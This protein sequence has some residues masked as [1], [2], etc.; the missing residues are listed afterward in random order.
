MNRKE[1]EFDR[2]DEEMVSLRRWPTGSKSRGTECV[3]AGVCL[4]MSA[5]ACL[6]GGLNGSSFASTRRPTHPRSLHVTIPAMRTQQQQ[7]LLLRHAA[8]MGMLAR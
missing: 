7:H 3:H 5:N 8:R 2:T 6:H 4:F 1:P